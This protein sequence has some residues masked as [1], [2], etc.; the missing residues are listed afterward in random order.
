MSRHIGVALSGG[1]HRASLWGL[2]A[3]LYL[4]DAGK[5]P[6]VA[7]ISSVSGGSITN[8]VVAHEVDFGEVDP[9]TFERRLTPL[10]RHVADT[11]LFFWGKST[12]AY[13][14]SVFAAAVVGVFA[15]VAGIVLVFWGGLTWPAGLT[16]LG[17]IVLL[18]ITARWFERRSD[19]VDGALARTHFSRD[20]VPT[21]L[22]GVDRSVDHVFCA[23]ELQ[24][25]D[26]LYLSPRFVSSYALGL[27]RPGDLQLST[28]VQASACLPGAFSPRRLPTEPHRFASGTVQPPREMVLVDGGVYDNM[29]DQWIDGLAARLERLPELPTRG[30]MI[31][32]A[33]VVNAS[34]PT[35]WTTVRASKIVLLSELL[36]LKRVSSVM[37]QVTTERR[38]HGLVAAWNASDRDGRGQRG[39]LVHIAQSPYLVADRYRGSSSSLERAERSAAVLALLGDT[40]EGRQYWS[41][42]AAASRT[43]PTVLRQLGREHSIDLL[44]HAYLL[45]MCN[46]HILLGYPLLSGAAR[47]RVARLLGEQPSPEAPV[48]PAR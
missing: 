31:D 14:L 44:E 47:D 2:G 43:M 21:A 28:A 48:M 13:V 15:M 8:G 35:A 34:S 9:S 36:T 24:S 32:E 46:L 29:A 12:N 45:A 37:Y 1:G 3:L 18:A 16:L 38:R 22:S 20:G 40:K 39:S 30:R 27:G 4:V 26:H 5:Q 6:E 11:G 23:T 10:V 17:A 33:I 42:R 7:V 25:G 41:R 19:V